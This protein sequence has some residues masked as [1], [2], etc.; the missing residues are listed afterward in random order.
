LQQPDVDQYHSQQSFTMAH[1]LYL[2]A[3]SYLSICDQ[4]GFEC[5]LEVRSRFIHECLGAW[6]SYS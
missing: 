2:N 3:I 6:T 1:R 5:S 4:F